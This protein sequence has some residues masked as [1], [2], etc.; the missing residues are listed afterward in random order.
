[1]GES[2]SFKFL[3]IH[4]RFSIGC[5]AAHGDDDQGALEGYDR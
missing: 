4:R 1:M 5:R 2:E 3:G